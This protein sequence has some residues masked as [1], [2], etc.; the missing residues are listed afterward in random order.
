LLRSVFESVAGELALALEFEDEQRRSRERQEDLQSVRRFLTGMNSRESV[1][2]LVTNVVCECVAEGATSTGLGAAFA[3][4]QLAGD[5]V[6][7]R[8]CAGDASTVMLFESEPVGRIW[9]QALATRR[10][11]AGDLGGGWPRGNLAQVVAVPLEV[12]GEIVG[13]LV[14]GWATKKLGLQS[15]ERLELRAAIAA[16]LLSRDHDLREASRR[17]DWKTSLLLGS[18]EA[19]VLL[20]AG[21]EIIGISRGAHQLKG[22]GDLKQ[23]KLAD[24]S[25]RGYVA[26]G[27]PIPQHFSELF[28]S[29]DRGR[30]NV[31]LRQYAPANGGLIGDLDVPP[32]EAQLL[33]EVPVRAILM[34]PSQDG[35]VA[36]RLKK[37]S[38]DT[39]S[40][41]PQADAE[42]HA[43]V[44]WLEEGVLV[45]DAEQNIRVIN[46]RFA[47]MAGLAPE[48]VSQFATLNQ[49]IGKLSNQAAEPEAFAE[50]WRKLARSDAATREE[51][52]FLQPVPRVLERSARPV[53]HATGRRSGWLEVYRDL[54]A[55]RVFQSKLLQTEKLAALGQ[56][57]TGVAHEL[58]NPLTSIL[59]YA[60]RLLL[61]GD[62][63]M[64]ARQIFQ[65]SERAATI[66]RQLL[67]SARDSQPGRYRVSLNEV[68]H[69][70][71]E[72]QRFSLVAERVSLELDL[73]PT[74]PAI[75]GDAGQLQQV[76]MNLVGNAR[77]AI[78]QTEGGGTIGIR[79]YV[80]DRGLIAVEV[81]DD[82]P[83]IPETIRARIF[84]PFFTTKPA[85]IGTGLGLAIV[86]G[87]VRE[88]GGHVEVFS[89]PGGGA[90]FTLEFPPAAEQK[91]P[92]SSASQS[93]QNGPELA[94]VSKALLFRTA[95]TELAAW[96]GAQVLVIEDEPTVARLIGDVLED[97]GLRVDILLDAKEALTRATAKSYALVICDVRMP[98][99]DGPQIYQALVRQV[100]AF[101]GKFLFITGDAAAARTHDFLEQ[102][103]LPH[104]PKPFRVEE[105]IEKVLD[106]LMKTSV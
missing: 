101:Q 21:A 16:N 79:T 99:I 60:Q 36:I 104:L 42:L 44:E 66:V 78:D 74:L 87:I 100:G 4:L 26:P 50:D 72:L 89:P 105:L 68:I 17:E 91:N 83:G 81:R 29:S 64:E 84:D 85:G 25:S 54:T 93:V 20:D 23:G 51:V 8:W 27:L 11:L 48:E 33:N 5:S 39:T 14:A 97:A 90:T 88:H 96:S 73:D 70:T 102:Y 12:H 80:S 86:L 98:E 65:E 63:S 103:H 6:G 43:L 34:L 71:M 35:S 69:R 19:I 95:S 40:E 15:V 37:S 10:T 31:W 32:V 9:H 30:V 52:Q 47:Q 53:L 2:H 49:L 38:S 55:Q 56:M 18:D 58:S 62:E 75:S 22:S 41:I 106:V 57:L 3:V 77:Q 45:F 7:Q 1:D 13:V 92:Y 46:S 76:L 24:S 82:G 61:R 94:P 67:T 59:G 28:R